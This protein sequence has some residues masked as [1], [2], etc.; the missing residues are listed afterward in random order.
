MNLRSRRGLHFVL[1]AQMYTV[2]AGLIRF[3][4][5]YGFISD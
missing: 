4:K 5:N 3:G 2:L 1:N